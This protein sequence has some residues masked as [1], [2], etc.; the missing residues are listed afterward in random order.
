MLTHD[1]VQMALSARADGEKSGLADDVVDLHVA[2]CAECA[3]FQ[4]RL[5][6]MTGQ[7]FLG[8]APDS[9]MAPPE[10]LSDIILA[11]VEPTWRRAAQER[12]RG[13]AVSRVFLVIIALA[14]VVW[15]VALLTDAAGLTTFAD[16][17]ASGEKVLSPDA[18]PESA[19]AFVEA[20]AI[21]MGLAVG[22]GFVAY[23]PN[24]AVALLSVCGTLT[25][26]VF[27]FTVRDIVLGQVLPSQI[28]FL[29]LSALAALGLIGMWA[30]ERGWSIPGAWRALGSNSTSS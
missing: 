18:N 4:E 27:G 29:V 13:I 19:A 15:A 17:G 16:T 25:V 7:A 2:N 5:A 3:S 23:R 20:A 21:R 22:L 10:D 6:T 12:A 9:T 28:Y 1:Q 24:M 26:F 30:A 14:F 8:E 11:G